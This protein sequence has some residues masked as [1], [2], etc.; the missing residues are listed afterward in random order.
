LPTVAAVRPADGGFALSAAEPHTALPALLVLLQKKGV[1]P[2]GLGTRLA[3][4]DDVFLALTG[5]HLR[6]GDDSA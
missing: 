6:D 3:T 5:R 1:T 2:T 4:L